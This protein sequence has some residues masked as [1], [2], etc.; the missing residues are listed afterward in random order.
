MK[1]SIKKIFKS[2][3]NYLLFVFFMVAILVL[4][5]FEHDLSL[6]K[7]NNLENQKKIVH[8]LSQLGSKDIEL[9][10]IQFNGKSTQL[11]QDIDKLVILYKYNLIEQ[12]LV[13]NSEEYQ[14]D[15]KHLVK[16]VN[17]F[18]KAAHTYY[19][20]I[21]KTK[22]VE[23]VSQNEL[24]AQKQLQTALQDVT[25]YIN[26]MLLKHLGY[27]EAKFSLI[28]NVSIGFFIVIFLF[29]FLFRNR[30]SKIYQD[31]EF[32]YQLDK[33]KK[34]YK[35]FSQEADAIALRMNRKVIT[36]DNPAMLDKVTGINNYK[37]M[38]NS[39]SNKKGLKDSNFTSV[40]VLEI[41]NFSKTN[42]PYPEDLTQTILKKVAYT[43][44]L[45][46]Q[47]ADVIARTDYNQ[48]II[49]LSRST[50]EQCYKDAEM[51]RQSISDL[52][53][54]VP[55]IGSQQI[56]VSGGHVS[57]P[58]NT[59]LEEAIKQAKEIL[60][61]AKSTGKNKIFQARDIAHRELK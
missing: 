6:Q 53:F 37:G 28:K 5:V 59:S 45:Y 31:I 33:D 43:I 54:N 58:S 3:K 23:T 15:L 11:Q 18:N 35:I 25:A 14:Q 52:K 42:R 44:S 1:N 21:L 24:E 39:Y 56:T 9:A 48:Y 16:L 4:F 60:V 49:I 26:G 19:E 29:T 51:I 34:G 46:E 47:P 38:V 61:V 12:Y 2:L 8:K 10:L 20:D 57:K 13:G 41:D 22:R 50:K 30:L 40:S 36:N 27:D 55:N 17:T 7:V 32:L